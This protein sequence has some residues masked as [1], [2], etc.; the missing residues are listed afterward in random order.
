LVSRRGLAVG[1]R[2]DAEQHGE[3]DCECEKQTDVFGSHCAFSDLKG[4]SVWSARRESASSVAQALYWTKSSE[5]SLR[6]L[7]GACVLLG[8]Q[9]FE[10]R[11]LRMEL[12]GYA[13][14]YNM[15]TYFQLVWKK[16][17]WLM[18]GMRG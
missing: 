8:R 4:F 14:V 17:G 7:A 1:R 13:S 5:E 2:V 16:C 10:R 12:S 18:R 15:N 3:K 11:L 6:F 9:R